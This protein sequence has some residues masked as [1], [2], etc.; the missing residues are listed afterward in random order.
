M[1]TEINFWDKIR[2]LV[3]NRCNYKCPFCHNEGQTT[4]DG[5]QMMTYN[6][7]V[8]IIDSIKA[9]SI[10]EIC[11]SGGEPFLNHD[12]VKMIQYANDNTDCDISCASN[13]SLITDQQ[14][15][16]LA[17]T[18]VKFNIQFPYL[19]PKLFKQSTGNGQYER[20][21]ENVQKVKSAGI[22]IG[23]NTVI[24]SNDVRFIEDMI[25]F[26]INNELPLK[27]LPQ[28]GLQ[29]SE[30]FKD[31]TFAI[32]RKYSDN[33]ID[34]GTGAYRWIL[35]KNNHATTVLYIDAPCFTHDIVK[36]RQYGEVRILPSLRI[37]TCL[38]K[39]ATLNHYGNDKNKF[40]NDLRLAWN[41]FRTC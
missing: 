5:F 32:L 4:I 6:Q 11:F 28:I 9:E 24:Q 1:S 37:Q 30:N 2:I 35:R 25:E 26:A 17:K 8:F 41:N 20:I 21:I 31:S 19:D 7:L 39:E 3:T 13:L 15:N 18:R 12:I 38:L 23:L 29:G 33:C 16:E 27:L 10:S 36:C 14:I 22:A 40:I 34:K